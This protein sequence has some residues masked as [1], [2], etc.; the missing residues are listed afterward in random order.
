[1]QRPRYAV[2]TMTRPTV[3]PVP[4]AISKAVHWL[5]SQRNPNGTWGKEAGL[6]TFICTLH[7][8]AALMAVG[9]PCDRGLVLTSL[10]FLSKIDTNEENSFYWRS[11]TLLNV[12]GYEEVVSKDIEFLQSHSGQLGAHTQY[13]AGMFL[14]KLLK[15]RNS[16]DEFDQGLKSAIHW[17]IDKW[18]SQDCW[19]GRAS[20]TSMGV[21]LLYDEEFDLKDEVLGKSIDFLRSSFDVNAFPSFSGNLVEDAYVLFNIFETEFNKSHWFDPLRKPLQDVAELL[22][23]RISADG[24][25]DCRAPFGGKMDSKIYPTAVAVRALLSYF[26]PANSNLAQDVVADFLSRAT[27]IGIPG[28]EFDFCIW[29]QFE[30]TKWDKCFVLMPFNKEFD[31]VYDAIQR[32]VEGALGKPCI[33]ADDLKSSERCHARRVG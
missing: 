26:S 13:P 12:P 21:A 25:V 11:G 33:R 9:L 16:R 5:I 22:V 4:S 28:S 2:G 7:V 17:A 29:G 23:E 10:D 15:F 19:F 30:S 1:M 20:I 31:V 8:A 6:D 27:S 3:D 18:R 14:L 24:F 32:A